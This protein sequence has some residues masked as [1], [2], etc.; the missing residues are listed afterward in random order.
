MSGNYSKRHVNCGGELSFIE[1]KHT[2]INKKAVDNFGAKK[3]YVYKDY[4][5]CD[6]CGST[7]N[8]ITGE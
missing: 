2:M 8:I 7:I 6:K 4:Y 1:T 5:R 3:K